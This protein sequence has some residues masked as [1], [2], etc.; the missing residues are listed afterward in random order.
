MTV[1]EKSRLPDKSRETLR[2]ITEPALASADVQ[3][4]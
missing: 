3:H 1:G 4:S 2:R